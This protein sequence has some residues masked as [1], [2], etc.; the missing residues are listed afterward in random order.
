MQQLLKK[1]PVVR[2]LLIAGILGTFTVSSFSQNISSSKITECQTIIK[3]MMAEK[4]VVGMAI[5]VIQRGDTV[6]SEGFGFADLENQTKVDP[7]TTLFRVGSVSKPLTSTAV[8]K[9]YE[10]NQLNLDDKIHQYVPYFPKKRYP[11]TV[12]HLASHT[13]GIRHYSS[14]PEE[15]WN[16]KFFG[17]VKESLTMFQDDSLLFEPG[18][19]FRYSSFGYNTLSAVIEGASGSDYLS[20]LDKSIFTPLGMHHTIADFTDSVIVGR[21]EP[22]QY[23]TV[24]SSVINTDFVDNSYKWAGG[25]LLSTTEDMAT[26]AW[27]FH[28][29]QIVSESTKQLFTQPLQL[30]SGEYHAYA[31]GWA[32][33]ADLSDPNYGHGGTAIGGKGSIKIYP[34]SDLVIAIAANVWKVGYRD[35]IDQV[36]DLWLNQ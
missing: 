24:S 8:A 7:A 32:R 3:K 36:I 25:G 22:Y 6:W 21:S 12:R 33:S 31:L 14:E 28:K 26:F 19:K 34:E 20:Y 10:Q 15:Y 5:T 27:A 23:D 16:Q 13:S 17:S 30:N 18:E 11:I 9:L 1:K 4:H 2:L 29:N 35:E